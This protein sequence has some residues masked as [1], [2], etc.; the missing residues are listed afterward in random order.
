MTRWLARWSFLA[1]IASC[2]T[3][4][5]SGNQPADGGTPDTTVTDSTRPDAQPADVIDAALDA[6]PGDAA[7][8]GALDAPVVGP[9]VITLALDRTVVMAGQTVVGTAA[10]R[11]VSGA[12][13]NMRRALI[14]V[15]RPGATHAGGPFDDFAP[16]LGPTAVAASTASP[17]VASRAFTAADPVG[18]WDAYATYENDTGVFV[19]GPSVHLTVEVPATSGAIALGSWIPGAPGDP[20]R[21]D[22]FTT[23]VG[24][25]PSIVHWYQSW[26]GAP[27]FST[28]R[29]DAVVAHGAMPMLTWEPWDT[30]GGVT[31]PTYTL[32][33]IVA[34]NHDAYLRSYARAA[35]A[36]G[37]TFY[38]RIAHEMNGDWYPWCIG[39]NGNTAAQY[40]A[41]WRHVVDL[42]RAEGATNVRW[43]WCPNVAYTGSA[44]FA[45]VYPGDAYVDWIGLDGYNRGTSAPG[46][47]WRPLR[48]VFLAS[49]DALAALTSRPMMIAEVSSAEQGGDKAAWIRTGLLTDLAVALPR[50]RA[51]VWF[52]ELKEAD[53]RVNSSAASLAAFSE[54]AASPLFAGH[55]PL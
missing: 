37:H 19:D 25:A 51:V 14:T 16:G 8:D 18:A 45:S 42:F 33:A 6:I 2:L 24:T 55:L 31:Q 47:S 53:W 22:A 10:Y 23:L 44:P 17:L 46:S 13:V 54:V 15:R 9:I 36:W 39:V 48:D 29:F 43:V 34:G 28:A 21:I 38:L 50:V 1:L 3:L 11:N 52:D 49:H 26:A 7:A 40:V 5:C 27:A 20:T 35:A 41:A 12:V 32:S 30:S 4:G